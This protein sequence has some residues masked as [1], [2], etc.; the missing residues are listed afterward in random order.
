[1]R[2]IEQYFRRNP[3]PLDR[4]SP[5]GAF[6]IEGIEDPIFGKVEGKITEGFT[7]RESL[8]EP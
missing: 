4:G 3:I 6:S 8:Y 5:R 7:G 1:M 2:R